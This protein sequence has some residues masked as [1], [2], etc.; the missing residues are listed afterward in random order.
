MVKRGVRDGI[1]MVPTGPVTAESEEHCGMRCMYSRHV[2]GDEVD[3]LLQ[4][5]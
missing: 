2:P 5:L 4:I 3:N 1:V